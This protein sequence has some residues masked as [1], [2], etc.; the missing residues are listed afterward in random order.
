MA[1]RSLLTETPSPT[2]RPAGDILVAT[3]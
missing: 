1:V 3:Q 2:T